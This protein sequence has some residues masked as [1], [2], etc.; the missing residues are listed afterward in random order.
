M[1]ESRIWHHSLNARPLSCLVKAIQF[2]HAHDRNEF[3]LQRDLE[4]SHSE[5]ANFQKLRYWGL[6]AQVP[7]K[8]GLLADHEMGRHVL[9]RRDR[10]AGERG[11]PGQSPNRLVR[12]AHPHQRIAREDS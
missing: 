8:R 12:A 3:H 9:A 2:V 4:L 7:E 6:V 1:T 10:H 5:Y 11:D